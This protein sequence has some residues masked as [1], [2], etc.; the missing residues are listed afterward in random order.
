[1]KKI[2]QI[3]KDKLSRSY[4]VALVFLIPILI[5]I[6]G[7][8]RINTYN[9]NINSELR[10]K[11]DLV[12]SILSVTLSESVDNREYLQ[13]IIDQLVAS[14]Q[15][16]SSISL[17][18]R[19]SNNFPILA[20]TNSGLT[21]VEIIDSQLAKIQI[22]SETIIQS[23]KNSLGKRIWLAAGPIKDDSGATSAI[24]AITLDS[25]KIDN[26]TK[27]TINQ[28][29]ISL[30]I[31]VFVVFLLLLNHFRFFE[32]FINYRKIEEIDR[33][34]DEFISMVFSFLMR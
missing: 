32:Y 11:V 17:I 19:S 6:N 20:S 14:E 1:M 21:G 23:Y 30:V 27:A 2:G 33:M 3:F 7:L 28:S 31:T 29:L 18:G 10:A 15:E 9:K 8:W 12:Q 13:Q 22:T 16:I 5:I 25:T 24:L 4:A 34:K 26:L